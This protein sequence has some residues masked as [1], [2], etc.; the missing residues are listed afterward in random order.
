MYIY[1]LFVLLSMLDLR[2]VHLS[3]S[4]DFALG[5]GRQNILDNGGWVMDDGRW[6]WA[7]DDGWWTID[8]ERWIMDFIITL[9]FLCITFVFSLFL[10]ACSKPF[11]F[12]SFY[13]LFYTSVLFSPVF[14]LCFLCMSSAFLKYFP[15]LHIVFPLSCIFTIIP[16]Y[17][18][19]IGPLVT[20]LDPYWRIWTNF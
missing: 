5:M 10:L 16:Q 15:R 11:L 2:D 1:T 17:S 9:Y 8:D 18:P 6:R 3:K 13:F 12:F 4:A 7:I 19:C 14:P 20:H